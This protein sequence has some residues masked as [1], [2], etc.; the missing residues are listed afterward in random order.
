MGESYELTVTE[1]IVSVIDVG[2]QGPAGPASTTYVHT[3]S[4][5]SDE[6]VIEHGLAQYPSVTVVDSAG[7]TIISDVR[8]DTDSSLTVFFSAS[9]SGKAYLN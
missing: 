8:Y 1:E 3:Q 5:P 4:V 6:W 7:H 9:F 2:I